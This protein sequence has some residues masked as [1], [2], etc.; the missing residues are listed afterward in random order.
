MKEPRYLRQ[1]LAGF[2][3]GLASIV[4][5]SVLLFILLNLA[6]QLY[7]DSKAPPAKNRSDEGAVM[8]HRGYHPS[9]APAYPGM[10]EGRVADLIKE[11]RQLTQGYEAHTQFKERPANATY[12]KVHPAGFRHG[13]SQARWPPDNTAFN[14]LFLGALPHSDIVSATT[15]PYPHICKK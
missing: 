10:D 13:R 1:G 7:L 3:W 14:I 4:L 9:L 15:T 8:A 2:Y 12:V 11:A 6:A 5:N